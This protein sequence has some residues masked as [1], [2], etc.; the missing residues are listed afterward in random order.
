MSEGSSHYLRILVN[1]LPKDYIPAKYQVSIF[2]GLA[3]KMLRTQPRDGQVGLI[4]S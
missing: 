2:N 3:V 1:H 4:N